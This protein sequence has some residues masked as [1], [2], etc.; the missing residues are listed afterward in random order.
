MKPKP[1]SSFQV[2]SFPANRTMS[3]LERLA[4]PAHPLLDLPHI[5]SRKRQS[6]RTHI[7]ILRKERRPRHERH[8]LLD[9]PLSELARI[10]HL[11]TG[12]GEPRPEEQAALRLRELD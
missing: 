6:E 5:R 8:A 3:G 4:Q 1:R 10:L 2:C 12:A 9:R 7:R 11:A